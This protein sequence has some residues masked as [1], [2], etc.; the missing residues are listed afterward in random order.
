MKQTITNMQGRFAKDT[1][2]IFVWDFIAQ[3][4]NTQRQT[5]FP[6]LKRSF[7]SP[8]GKKSENNLANEAFERK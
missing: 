2:S 7:A 5:F 8:G 4:S 3:L 6:D 1:Y